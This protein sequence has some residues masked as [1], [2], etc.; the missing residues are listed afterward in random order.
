VAPSVVTDNLV[1]AL[2]YVWRASGT[3]QTP[4]LARI[5]TAVFQALYEH[6]LTL[7]EALKLLEF[8]NH[9][10]RATLAQGIKDEASR[11]TLEELNA[12]RSLDYHMQIGITGRL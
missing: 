2:T 6:K 10:F 5:A 12:L 7:A 1:D 4:L 9:A 8:P 3:D 11:G